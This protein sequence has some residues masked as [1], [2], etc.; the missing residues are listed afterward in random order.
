MTVG[1][2]IDAAGG[3]VGIGGVAIPS[4]A[5]SYA[6]AT[7][8]RK[9]TPELQAIEEYRKALCRKWAVLD[10][11]GQPILV[12]RDDEQGRIV[13]RHVFTDEAAFEREWQEMRAQPVTLSGVRAVRIAEMEGAVVSPD[14]LFQLGPFVVAE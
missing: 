1:E 12:G 10:D 14:V 11:A 5:A 4:I 8:K 9:A 6:F 2:L 13:M 7:I 3:L